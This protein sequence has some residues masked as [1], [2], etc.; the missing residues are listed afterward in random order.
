MVVYLER[1][2][3]QH[4]PFAIDQARRYISEGR[5]GA[6]DLAWMEGMAQWQPI[7]QVLALQFDAVPI[8]PRAAPN[9]PEFATFWRRMSALF[10]DLAIL[11]MIGGVA[12]FVL[13][14]LFG[15][16]PALNT[17]EFSGETTWI[18]LM[19]LLLAPL[20]LGWLYFAFF[21]VS[22]YSAT[23]GKMLLGLVLLDTR[24]QPLG[25]LPS[26]LR[27][28]LR[29]P[30]TMFFGAT[31]YTQPLSAQR[32]TAHDMIAGS[33]VL[34]RAPDAGLPGA[35]LWGINIAGALLVLVGA[36]TQYFLGW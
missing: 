20:A 16:G 28:A 19:A 22:K 5:F 9:A 30:G 1:D 21:N 2:G 18:L 25:L 3:Q 32:Q 8:A 34:R 36:F 14:L 26:L 33:V 13:V 23:P 24:A 7:D 6:Q 17:F 11:V 4:G 12:I 31:Y 35:A 15:I 27:E 10:V 29:I